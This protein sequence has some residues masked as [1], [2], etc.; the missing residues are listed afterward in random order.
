MTLLRTCLLQQ[1]RDS[2][3]RYSTPSFPLAHCALFNF[4]RLAV[5]SRPSSAIL[6][7]HHNDFE[8]TNI[9]EFSL[10]RRA[11][12]LL[13]TPKRPLWKRLQ[14]PSHTLEVSTLTAPAT[15]AIL[16][17]G[18]QAISGSSWR[19]YQPFCLSSRFTPP[20]SESSPFSLLFRV[21]REL[22]INSVDAST[23]GTVIAAP[24]VPQIL[25]HF[26]SQNR[27]TLHNLAC[28]DL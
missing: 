9:G 21:Y 13:Q 3:K 11:S 22:S 6:L 26:Q 2:E 8:I 5:Q 18:A 15:H 28:L 20:C 14:S 16:R 27:L 10:I 12:C 25:T 17:M 4:L 1:N 19:W 24:S 23:L 7:D